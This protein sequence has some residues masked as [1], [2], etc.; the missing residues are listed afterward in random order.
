MTPSAECHTDH[1]LVQCISVSTS[2]PSKGKEAFHGR[3]C[4]LQIAQVRVTSRRAYN[5]CL[6]SLA[7]QR[8]QMQMCYRTTSRLPF[9]KPL[10]KSSDSPQTEI[11]SG[12]TRTTKKSRSCWQERDQHT[13]PTWLIC[14]DRR[15]KA[16][17]RL[18]YS[19]LQQN[20]LKCPERV[21]DSLRCATG[22]FRGFHKDLYGPSYRTQSPLRSADGRNCSILNHLSERFHTLCN[23]SHTIQELDW[24]CPA[25]A[26]ENW[27]GRGTNT[28][29]D[30][31]GH[32][33]AEE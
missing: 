26:G 22:N 6:K 33:A 19:L 31:E 12:S 7:S 32:R 20:V 25:T 28:A 11:K 3:S 10:N 18:A 4:N 15:K 2:N 21:V 27:T 8:T 24:L 1:R 17:F 30:C 23:A 13:C 16:A 14:S 9:C 5:R 29:T